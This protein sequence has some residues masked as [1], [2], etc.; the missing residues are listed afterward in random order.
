MILLS[1]WCWE[2]LPVGRPTVLD[3]DRWDDHGDPERMATWAC[4][5]DKVEGFFGVSKTH[6]LHYVNELDVMIPE[7]VSS[8]A[9]FPSRISMF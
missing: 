6:Y 3:Y 7:H 5:W 9:F 2:R 4:H 1:D 8:F